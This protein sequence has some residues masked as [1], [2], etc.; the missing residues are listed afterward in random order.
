[1]VARLPSDWILLA[2][3]AARQAQERLVA[4][5]VTLGMCF[6]TTYTAVCCVGWAIAQQLQSIFLLFLLALTINSYTLV[7]LNIKES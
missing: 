5:N 2:S 3:M 4:G 1:V 7:N 6:P